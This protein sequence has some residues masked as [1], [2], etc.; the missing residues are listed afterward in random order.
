MPLTTTGANDVLTG[1]LANFLYVSA[2]TDLGTTEATGVTRQSVAWAAAASKQRANS[3]ALTIPV[4]A[5]QTVVAVG[6]YSAV[7]AGN[8]EAWGQVGSTVRGVGS[9]DAIATDLIQSNGHGLATDDRV[10][11]TTVSGEALPAGLSAST[12]YFVR[13]TGLTA[14]AFT[15]ATTSGGA[16]VDI[17]GLGE[18]AFFKT[19]AQPFPS[20][21]NLVVAIGQLIIDLSMA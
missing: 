7:S 6:V 19:T 10:F 4:G 1:G 20:G 8:Q 14:D 21:G 13:A 11:F 9:V 3:G 16:A 17:T 5:G 2:L 12:L 15:V 18:V